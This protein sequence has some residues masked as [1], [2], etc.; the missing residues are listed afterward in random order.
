[1]TLNREYRAKVRTMYT[2]DDFSLIIIRRIRK[3]ILATFKSEAADFK[4]TSG[5]IDRGLGLVETPS[6]F[7]VIRWV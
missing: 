5:F 1:M 3:Q 6:H 7:L 4:R 2:C